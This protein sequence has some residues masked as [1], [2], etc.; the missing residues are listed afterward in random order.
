M[1]QKV[2]FICL[3][4]LYEH[5]L[6]LYFVIFYNTVFYSY[7]ITLLVIYNQLMTII[8][9]VPINEQC[10]YTTYLCTDRWCTDTDLS[11]YVINII[12][13]IKCVQLLSTLSVNIKHTVN[14]LK[15]LKKP[16]KKPKAFIKWPLNLL[17]ARKFNLISL[18]N[19]LTTA[20]TASSL[21]EML[22]SLAS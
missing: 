11:H 13:I 7:R 5:V 18:R 2:H 6:F 4:I 9:S 16:S 21:L 1:G 22:T 17:K 10:F 15:I 19:L 14:K 20:N 3:I 8:I 12:I